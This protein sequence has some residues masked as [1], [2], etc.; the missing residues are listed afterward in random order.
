[1]AAI[2]PLLLPAEVWCWGVAGGE[3]E[4]AVG[5]LCSEKGCPPHVPLTGMISVRLVIHRG[6]KQPA[7]SLHIKELCC[8]TTYPGA[9]AVEGT[10]VRF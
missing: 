5:Q 6:R 10:L 4:A 9:L 2:Q 7:P 3:E 8:C 1:M